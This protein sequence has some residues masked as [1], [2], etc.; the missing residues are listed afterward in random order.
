MLGQQVEKSLPVLL[1]QVFF[2]AKVRVESRASNIRAIDHVLDGDVI[3]TFFLDQL[4]HGC[5]QRA[6]GAICSAIRFFGFHSH[7]RL[8]SRTM[9]VALSIF[10]LPE[11]INWRQSPNIFVVSLARWDELTF[12]EE[13]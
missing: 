3:E 13:A 4:N 12:S 6:S 11:Q 7:G 2:V 9:L 5:T 1:K 8:H 10:E